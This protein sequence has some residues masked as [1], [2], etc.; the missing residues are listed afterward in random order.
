[1]SALP[2][3]ADI[4]QRSDVM[5]RQSLGAGTVAVIPIPFALRRAAAS[6]ALGE[7]LPAFRGIEISW[8]T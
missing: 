8:L 2:P 1:M 6:T 4:R 7:R 5:K 3:K